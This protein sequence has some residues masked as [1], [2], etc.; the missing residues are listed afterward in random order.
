[1]HGPS[2]VVARLGP[3]R[4]EHAAGAARAWRGLPVHAQVICEL[5]VGTFSPAGTFAGVAE[6]LSELA[7][8]GYTALE[9]MPVGEFPGT[10]NWGYDGV[11]VSAAQSS[12]GG[13]EELAALCDAAHEQGLAVLLDVV[14]NHLGP[15]GSVHE[16]FGPYFTDRYATPWGHAIN[17]D[18]PGSDAVRA[19]FI[20]SACY[21]VG[22]IGIDG[23]RLDAVHAI[24]DPTARPFLG[25]LA[26]AVH[27]TG[28]A[29]GRAVSVVAENAS[30]DPR[31][32]RPVEAGGL[33]LDGAWDD[34]FHHGLRVALTGERDR[35]FADFCGIEDLARAM[36]DGYALAGRPSVAFGHRHGALPPDGVRGEELVVYAQNHDQIGNA[37]FGER[38]AARLPLEAQFPVSAAVLL[39]PFVPLRFMG[40]EYGETAPFFFFTSH[41]DRDLIEAVR[42]GRAAEV[43][44][45]AGSPG[46]DPQ[47]PATFEASRPHRSLARSGLHA[48]L[49]HWQ[50]L[51]LELRRNE[52]AL[53]SLDARRTH[54]HAEVADESLIWTR[55][56]DGYLAAPAIAVVCRF[57]REAAP[58]KIAVDAGPLAGRAWEVLACRGAVDL[59]PGAVLGGPAHALGPQG[60]DV[61]VSLDRYAALVLRERRAGTGTA[62]AA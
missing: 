7:A 20:E 59:S 40:E 48:E 50:R 24:V 3:R 46:P 38:I 33:G 18:G 12:Y 47:D 1:V 39:A 58:G 37:G 44:A 56:A 26:E 8:A 27:A 25:E 5:H 49:L 55:H 29:V 17:L 11:F 2:E 34:D 13:P 22:E 9:L 14:Y 35:W 60:P 36:T 61:V 53:G 42:R 62:S 21:F 31:L 52:P 19:Y 54:A 4:P 23:L 30:N 41:G 51:L 6:S 28:R 16:H 32:F 45:A 15:E 43:G 57:A 10:R